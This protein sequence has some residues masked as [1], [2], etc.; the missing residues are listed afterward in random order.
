MTNHLPNIDYKKVSKNPTIDADTSL[1]EIPFYK[2]V[3]Y[4]SNL[5]NFVG[6]VKSVERMVRT[7]N[8]YSRYIKYLKEDIGLTACQVLSN[9]EDEYADIEMHHGPI[10]TLFDYASIITDWMLA[11]NKKINTFRVADILLE[12]HFNNN[13]QVVMLSKTVHEQ[14]HENNIYINLNQ[15]FGDLN[16]F[17]K[18]YRSGLHPEQIQKINKYIE[19]STQYESFDKGVLDLTGFVKKWKKENEDEE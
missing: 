4:F 8:Y 13:I 15:A 5:D 16:A 1:F 17:L 10:L 19:S 12:E 7:S 18:K 2:D 9:I 3:E 14:V 11:T 6:F